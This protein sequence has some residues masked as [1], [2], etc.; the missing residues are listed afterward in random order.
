MPNTKD[1]DWCYV[2]DNKYCKMYDNTTYDSSNLK[3]FKW[4]RDENFVQGRFIVKFQNGYCYIYDVDYTP[5][6]KMKQKAKNNES[7][8]EWYDNNLINYVLDRHKK[9]TLYVDRYTS[10]W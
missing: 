10:K 7:P 9:N 4:V 1:R 3:C 5:Y 2:H 8:F 6:D